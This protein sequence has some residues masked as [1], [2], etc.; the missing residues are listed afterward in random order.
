MQ[1]APTHV[2]FPGASGFSAGTVQNVVT[3]VTGT[4]STGT[5]AD[6]R[7]AINYEAQGSGGPALLYATSDDD[8]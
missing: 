5:I 7:L 3:R 6:V 4:D 2:R 1:T 8:G